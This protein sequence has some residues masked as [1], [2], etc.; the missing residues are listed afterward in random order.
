MDG[1]EE[2]SSKGSL[3]DSVDLGTRKGWRYGG[4]RKQ[5]KEE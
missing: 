4:K 5:E 3:G 2:M 1:W